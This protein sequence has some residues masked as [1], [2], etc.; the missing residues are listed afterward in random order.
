[1]V[2]Q[3]G[4]VMAPVVAGEGQDIQFNMNNDAK[5]KALLTES[6]RV[7][8]G[9]DEKVVKQIWDDKYVDFATLLHPEDTGKY[10]I[11]YE[12][13]GGVGTMHLTPRNKK[14][15]KSIHQWNKAFEIYA[16]IWLKKPGN[17]KY[18]QD[19]MTYARNVRDMA[20]DGLNWRLYDERFRFER[21]SF[22][23]IPKWG[24]IRQ[25]IYNRLIN[26]RGKSCQAPSN[27]PHD[28]ND[29]AGQQAMVIPKS[30]CYAYHSSAG[31]CDL[32]EKCAFKH[33]CFKCGRGYHPAFM[34]GR[35]RANT[36]GYNAQGY[37]GQQRFSGPAATNGGYGAGQNV[38]H[39]NTGRPRFDQPFRH[40][41]P[42]NSYQSR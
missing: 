36:G 42:T 40:Q 7:G 28:N 14:S 2:I 38:T 13:P 1:M 10:D 30:F 19:L 20:E 11:A 33:D 18:F 31:R 32:R 6:L 17:E 16:T 23:T 24:C 34:C 8:E 12:N 41:A 35:R 3:N 5:L 4:E 21:L 22:E 15:I 29:N 25:D 27:W 39:N 26:N 9:I 37:S